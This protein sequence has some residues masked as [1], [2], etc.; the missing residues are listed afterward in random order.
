MLFGQVL[1][2]VREVVAGSRQALL[3]AGLGLAACAIRRKIRDV[4]TGD[5]LA[6]CGYAR[7][8][9]ELP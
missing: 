2:D 6:Q 5:E 9:G 1:D 4:P 8:L 3:R 7:M